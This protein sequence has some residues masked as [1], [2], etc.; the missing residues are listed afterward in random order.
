MANLLRTA[1]S[2]SDW[3]ISELDAYHIEIVPVDPLDFFGVQALPPVP[4]QVDPEILDH[5]EATDMVQDRNAELIGLLDLAM[6]PKSGES[7]VD[8]FAVELFKVLGY[9]RRDRLARTRTD[10]PLLICGE[11][12]HAKTDVCLIDRSQNDIL[13]LVQEDKRIDG[14][15]PQAEAQLV[16]EAV[17]AFSQNNQ[18]RRDIGLPP[19]DEKI[20]PGI[21][22]L[23]TTPTFYKIP[24]SQSLLY[25][26][27]NGTYPPDLTQ[28]TC[29][30]VPVPRPARRYSEGMKPLDNRK[31]IFRCYEAFKAIVGI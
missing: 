23:G 30:A 22:M 18:S 26:I 25:H 12:R 29:C 1:K 14:K 24:V 20:M 11:Y 28:V 13:L 10:L 2:G 19:L 16:A 6:L 15:L 8:D 27:R 21:V 5:V 4:P 3:T 7:A 9:V 31:E 17:A